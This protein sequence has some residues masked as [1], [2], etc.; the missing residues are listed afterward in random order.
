[1]GECGQEG[2]TTE[3]SGFIRVIRSLGNRREGK[4]REASTG[5]PRVDGEIGSGRHQGMR[6]LRRRQVSVT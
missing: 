2:N 4:E 5:L 6:S 3:Q 1:M